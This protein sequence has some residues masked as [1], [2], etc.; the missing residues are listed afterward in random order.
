MIDMGRLLEILVS[1]LIILVLVT[2][3]FPDS[4]KIQDFVIVPENGF[5]QLLAT[6]TTIKEATSSDGTSRTVLLNVPAVDDSG[7]GVALTL[8]VQSRPGEG[9][10][11]TDINNLFFW[12]DTQ[13]SIR[14]A[15]RVA[16]NITKIDIS[17]IDLVYD[18]KTNASAIEGPSAG[19]ALTIATIAALENKN[20]NPDVMITGTINPDGTIGRVG[21]IDSKAQAAKEVG[22]KIFLI[23]AG[24]SVQTTY[25]PSENCET[26]GPLYYC[27]TE[28]KSTTVN[29]TSVSGLE[30]KEVS[31]IQEALKYFLK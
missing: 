11:L 26:I 25:Q 12:V 14:V 30:I 18:V 31:D 5:P 1:V 4:F 8:S 17:K 19:A 10:V 28:Y 16:Q 3:V 29:I 9:R 21:G 7:K 22:A 2:Y 23:P 15:Q 13:N 20:V 6:T 24:Q 27:N